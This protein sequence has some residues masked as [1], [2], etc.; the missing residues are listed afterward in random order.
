SPS[1]S[2]PP[3]PL[4][5]SPS[6]SLPLS[7]S[8]LSL[9]FS[10]SL[11]LSLSLSHSSLS[12]FLSLSRFGPIEYKGPFTALYV[13]R[14]IQKVITPLTYLPSSAILKDFLSYHEV[15]LPGHTL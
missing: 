8:L 3:S 9:L 10:L 13:E 14:F 15:L 5:L 6:L 11:S 7:H 12:L 1:L 4:S 2:L